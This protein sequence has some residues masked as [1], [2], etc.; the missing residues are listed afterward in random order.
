MFDVTATARTLAATFA[1]SW[2]FAR[3]SRWREKKRL[4]FETRQAMQSERAMM[5]EG[6]T[7]KGGR[8]ASAT[9]T[10]QRHSDDSLFKTDALQTGH[11][12][13]R[14]FLEHRHRR[15]G[16]HPD[17]QRRR[18]A[19][20]RLRRGRGGQPDHAGRHFRPAGDQ[21]ARRQA[22]SIEFDTR[23]TPGFEALV[24]KASRGIEDIYELTY[25]RKDGS[26]FPAMV[27]VTALRDARNAIIGYLLI[28][29]DNTARKRVEA[30][31]ALLDQDLQNKNVELA[32]AKVWRKKRI[33]P[34]PISSP[35]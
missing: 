14:Q 29:T 27:S 5:E 8:L 15:P 22:L 4:H 32:R 3:R 35:A 30:E 6:T 23:I 26:R 11:F 13:Q 16:R 2:L 34:N 31:R 21:R 24:F 9:P 12:Q 7:K 17:L 18:R 33:W 10:A 1:L 28:G 19:D 25:I 20:A